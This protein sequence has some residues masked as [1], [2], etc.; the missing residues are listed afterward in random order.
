MP[1]EIRAYRKNYHLHPGEI[2]VTAEDMNITTV[3]GSCVA[4]CI[5]DSRR[6]IGG[7]NHVL[8]PV[9]PKNQQ[10]SSR[11]GNV[12]TFVLFDMMLERGCHKGDLQ[13]SV[14]GGANS[15]IRGRSENKAMQVGKNNTD[16]TM[17]V[18]ERV[19]LVVK[20]KDTGGTIG[21]K[22]VFNCATGVIR[23]DFLRKFDFAHELGAAV[24]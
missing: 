14:F 1:S 6:H 9:H 18:L 2:F 5:W 17:K 7:M 24:L 23:A 16:V 4:V 20:Q 13:V 3:L 21:R 15:V 19:N 22:I 11:Y 8:L 10:P 12:A